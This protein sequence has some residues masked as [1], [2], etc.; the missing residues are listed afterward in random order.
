M[1]GAVGGLLAGKYLNTPDI[2]FREEAAREAL[3]TRSLAGPGLQATARAAQILAWGA[4]RAPVGPGPL[5]YS[6]HVL[7]YDAGRKKITPVPVAP[8]TPSL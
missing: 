7:E 4:P 3:P 8:S 6:N 5:V 1:L 2:T